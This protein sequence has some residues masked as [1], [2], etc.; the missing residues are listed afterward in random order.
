MSLSRRHFLAAAGACAASAAVGCVAN[1]APTVDASIDRLIPEAVC[2]ACSCDVFGW[3]SFADH[4]SAAGPTDVGRQI[5]LARP[6]SIG[7][8]RLGECR[9]RVGA[10]QA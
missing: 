8:L 10:S 6:G 7:R 3:C 1:P 9:P 4:V 2:V 5:G